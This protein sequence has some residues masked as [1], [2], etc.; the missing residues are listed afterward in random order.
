M[1]AAKDIQFI[2]YFKLKDKNLFKRTDIVMYYIN[3]KLGGEYLDSYSNN[4]YEQAI[5]TSLGIMWVGREG[6]SIVL[7]YNE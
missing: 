3:R 2:N 1:S 6:I 5:Y 4:T 7:K